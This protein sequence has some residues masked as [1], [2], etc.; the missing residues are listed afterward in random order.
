MYFRA[1]QAGHHG[2]LLAGCQLADELC[3]LYPVTRKLY[4]KAGFTECFGKFALQQEY[5]YT[6]QWLPCTQAC[7]SLSL[8][9]CR[10]AWQC[11]SPWQLWCTCTRCLPEEIIYLHV[12]TASSWQ[13]RKRAQLQLIWHSHAKLLI[14]GDWKKSLEH[15]CCCNTHNRC[16]LHLHRHDD[17]C[18]ISLC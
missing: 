6:E 11:A 14:R 10:L 9:C 4:A 3:F 13:S 7:W 2:Q 18:N 12:C 1:T 8:C 17:A 16:L 5:V 15:I